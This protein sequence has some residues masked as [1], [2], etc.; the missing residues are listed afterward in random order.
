ML[1]PWR[2]TWCWGSPR[3]RLTWKRELGR[4]KLGHCP[5][6]RRSNSL[7]RKLLPR[8]YIDCQ[9]VSSNRY[10]NPRVVIGKEVQ[11]KSFNRLTVC[12]G[13]SPTRN[14]MVSVVLVYGLTCFTYSLEEF[15]SVEDRVVC[16]LVY[17][18]TRQVAN[19]KS[20]QSMS[21]MHL[22][23]TR[24]L[25]NWIGLVDLQSGLQCPRVCSIRYKTE[26]VPSCIERQKVRNESRCA[27]VIVHNDLR[28]GA[29]LG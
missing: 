7:V 17:G 5:V 10:G 26:N 2:R 11:D 15:R 29:V 13:S 23:S 25:D 1:R 14:E 28:S 18:D 21:T 9:T 16:S 19:F 12:H 4:L 20:S 8:D 24:P 27:P 6:L 3:R 22:I